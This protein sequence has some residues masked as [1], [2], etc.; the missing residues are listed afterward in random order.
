MRV[1]CS[2]VIPLVVVAGS[3]VIKTYATLWA[4]RW[5]LK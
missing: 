2:S 1:I 4:L 5:H 3:V